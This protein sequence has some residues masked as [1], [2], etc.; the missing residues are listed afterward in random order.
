LI[1]IIETHYKDGQVY[2]MYVNEKW[3]REKIESEVS[4]S[5]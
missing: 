5:D 2:S 3:R 1:P 4:K